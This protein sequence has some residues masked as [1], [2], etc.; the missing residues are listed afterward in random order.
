MGNNPKRRI[1]SWG[2]I[3]STAL[4]RL[5]KRARYVGN[6]HHKR[7]PADYGFNPPTSP[8][9]YKSLCDGGGVVKW[10]EAA[11]LLREGLMRGMVGGLGA[12][13]FPKYVWSVDSRGRVYEAKIGRDGEYHGHELGDD[14]NTM[15]QWVMNEWRARC[16]TN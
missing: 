10:K 11:A 4:K 14:D 9:P 5:A 7:I 16:G 13:D 2:K 15:R 6:P 1:E 3:G 12:G 8:R